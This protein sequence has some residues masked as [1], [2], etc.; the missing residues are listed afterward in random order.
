LFSDL[1]EVYRVILYICYSSD[2]VSKIQETGNNNHNFRA[3][4]IPLAVAAIP[5]IA[6]TGYGI[7][8]AIKGAKMAKGLE[9][10]EYQ[11]PEEIKS[12]LSQAQRLALEGMTAE[13][14]QNWVDNI[15]R[16]GNFA[17]RALGDR[18]AGLA[19]IA[20]VQQG[21]TDAYRQVGETD[22]QMRRQN[23]SQLM[24]QNQVMAGYKDKEFELNEMNPFL[25]AAKAAES[26]K[27]AGV[28]N[29]FGGVKS[30]LDTVLSQDVY[31]QM[32][33]DGVGGGPA[34]ATTPSATTPTGIPPV[35]PTSELQVPAPMI[36]A[37]DSSMQ[38][39]EL[40]RQLSNPSLRPEE[41]ESIK[42]QIIQLESGN[43]GQ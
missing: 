43:A 14:Q 2:L 17:L 34:T 27:G 24:Q 19:G 13:E 36:G 41:R 5:A 37:T 23:I 8:Q 3:M 18:K 33:G 6:Q 20:G 22:A 29:I 12:N 42:Q 31:K 30:G 9:R 38:I 1:L 25:A 39:G 35:T 21:M 7:Y 40:K 28:Q 32:M 4:P 16:S 11:I 10:P 15:Q 26:M